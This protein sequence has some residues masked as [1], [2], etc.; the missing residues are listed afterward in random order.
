MFA[1]NMYE[2]GIDL[3]YSNPEVYIAGPNPCFAMN[4]TYPGI[5]AFKTGGKCKR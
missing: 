2:I 3:S 5:I 4:K 1:L